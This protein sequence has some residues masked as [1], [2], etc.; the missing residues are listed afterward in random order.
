M[1]APFTTPRAL[2]TTAAPRF[3]K[4]FHHRATGHV[5]TDGGLCFNNPVAIADQ[6]RELLWPPHLHPYPDILLS[7]GTGYTSTDLE[8]N[9]KAPEAYTSAQ[10]AIGYISRLKIIVSHQ[11]SRQLN[12]Q[13][14][15]EDFL[16]KMG[17]NSDRDSTRKKKY[18]RIDLH[19]HNG[20]PKL[21]QVDQLSAIESQVDEH[22][23]VPANFAI[24][25]EVAAQLVASLF[26][27]RLDK[28]TKCQHGFQLE[29]KPSAYWNR[30]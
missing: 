22:F 28:S 19:F 23:K 27:L 20:L 26:Y 11:T 13:R 2:G 9:E 4:P 24:L 5:F 6:E 25:E 1:S 3:F 10:G 17:I 7:L 15:W 21:H 18:R 8:D 29:G 14:I 12:S 16:E 30:P